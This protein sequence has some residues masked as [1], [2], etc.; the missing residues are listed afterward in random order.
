MSEFAHDVDIVNCHVSIMYQIGKSWHLWP[1]H[2][3][4]NAPLWLPM[5][6]WI[7]EDRME[8][9]NHV[10]DFH[11]FPPDTEMYLGYRKDLV[12]PLILRLMFGGWYDSWLTEHNLYHGRRS[13]KVDALVDEL[14]LLRRTL[15]RASRYTH[16]VESTIGRKN[17]DA[18]ERSAFAKIAQYME[19]QLLMTMRSSLIAAGWEILSLVFDG[20]IVL[21]REGMRLDFDALEKEVAWETTF[22]IR[23]LEKPLFLSN[24]ETLTWKTLL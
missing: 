14:T 2:V 12:K 19:C 8:F 15:V 20:L 17:Q 4:K 11:M 9:I 5:M 1:E 22:H 23:I 18:F 13:K 3:E 10:A 24:V 21:H 6:K 16:I 7:A